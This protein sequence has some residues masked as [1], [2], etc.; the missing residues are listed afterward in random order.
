[1]VK[2]PNRATFPHVVMSSLVRELPSTS[3]CDNFG[4][5]ENNNATNFS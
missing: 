4:L 2:D 5:I 1:M 3:K